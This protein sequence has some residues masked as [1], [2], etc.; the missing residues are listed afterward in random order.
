MQ[1]TCVWVKTGFGMRIVFMESNKFFVNRRRIFFLSTFVDPITGEHT[2]NIE[3][4]WGHC[5]SNVKPFVK[6]G[7]KSLETFSTLIYH[8]QWLFNMKHHHYAE[9]VLIAMLDLLR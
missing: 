3:R 8:F 2:N 9:D 6:G 1:D 4:C 7:V 5:K